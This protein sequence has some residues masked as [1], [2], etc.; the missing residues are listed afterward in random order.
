MGSIEWMSQSG[1]KGGVVCYDRYR[2]GLGRGQWVDTGGG[3]CIYG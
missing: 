3:M 1:R 2:Q